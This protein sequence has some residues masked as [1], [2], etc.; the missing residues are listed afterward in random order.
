MSGNHF[1]G[2][3]AFRLIKTKCIKRYY[4]RLTTNLMANQ[5]Q[6]TDYREP[7]RLLIPSVTNRGYAISG[8]PTARHQNS[9]FFPY[10][11]VI[12][13]LTDRQRRLAWSRSGPDPRPLLSPAIPRRAACVNLDSSAKIANGPGEIRRTIA[14]FLARRP[15]PYD[16]RKP[17]ISDDLDG[18]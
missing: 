11:V 13:Y 18:R 17:W 3:D 5:T 1:L 9:L 7:D 16:G 4:L 10:F 15:K 12:E 6:R 8:R 2:C 14:I